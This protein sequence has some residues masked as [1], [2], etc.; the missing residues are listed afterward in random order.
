M[1]T[2]KSEMI[3][4]FVLSGI[5]FFVVLFI[6]YK[7]VT[8][9][10]IQQEFQKAKLLADTLV[11][12]RQYLAK[13]APYVELKNK[14]FHPFSVTPAYA[15]TQI[16]TMI[17]KNEHIYVKQTSDR[18]RDIKNRPNRHELEAIHYLEKHPN[19]KEFVQIHK[20]HGNIKSQHLFYVYPLKVRKSCIK[21]HGTK[22]EV[23]TKLYNEIVK[24]YGNRA[25][26]Y[27]LGELRGVISVRI[28]FDEVK[29]NVNKLFIKI[30]ILF[31]ILYVG[32]IYFF[33][34]LNKEIIADIQKI[35][36][37][38]DNNLSKNIYKPF[39]EQ[40]NFRGFYFI[41]KGLNNA[42][43]ALKNY[44]KDSYKN[45]YYNPITNLP[46]RRRLL[47]ILER[48]KV[49]IILLDIDS[50]KEVNY[51]Y[52]EEIANKVIIEVAN[53]LKDKH[54]LFHIKIDEFAILM[55]NDITK[56]TIY[57]YT[58]DLIAKIEQPYKIDDY[59]III[60]FRA[61]I[62]FTKKSFVDALSALDATR[63]L[64]KE[65]V[66]CSEATEIREKYKDHL[67]WMKK[68]KE[69]LE[70][71]RVVPFFQP[72]VDKNKQICKYEALVRMLD[73][74]K[75]ISP[76]FFLDV[77]KKSRFYFDITKIMITK[78]L[79]K[80]KQHNVTISINLTTLDMENE[81]IRKFIITKL[82]NCKT[83]SNIH[84]EI[85]ESEDIRNSKEAFEFIKTI[86]S[87]GCKILIDD[88]GSGYANFD[89]LLSLGADAVKIDGTLIK[90]IL[91]DENSKIVVKT[92]ISFAKAVNMQVIAEF[93]EDDEVFEYLK[94]EGVD[95]YQ[96]YFY[97]PPKADL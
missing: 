64:N 37:Y 16:A 74:D 3:K 61:G 95:C 88:F 96:G 93:V 65:I 57:K 20:A 27:K 33:I 22:K 34:K 75:V 5:A 12:T 67:I 86:K 71:D 13:V 91:E 28:P 31:F 94:T 85:V 29:E 41:K 78:A 50:F 24:I 40:M 69:A 2:I 72:I 32:G 55:N 89:Y 47:E 90:N 39:K 4:L 45:L 11:Y 14:T 83:P 97:S 38:L 92:I 62:S 76:F 53:R 56:E 19:V 44:K 18:V 17:R 15:V 43:K 52:G 48:K 30:S 8:H 66:F 46:N 26:G 9:F 54:K 1:K 60:R 21:C 82:Q 81:D 10:I 84:F 70:H 35:Q 23:P 49:P 77:A 58:E 73:G 51:Y 68:L 87:F 42:V 59:S 80:I 63:I 7:S 36:K 6:L 79:E 25:F